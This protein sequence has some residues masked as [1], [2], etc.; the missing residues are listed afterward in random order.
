MPAA[1][2]KCSS[3]LAMEQF[4]LNENAARDLVTT[5]VEGYKQRFESFPSELFIH[6]R[7]PFADEEWE[8]FQSAV[9]PET[10]IVGVRIRDSAGLRLYTW[11]DNVALRGLALIMDDRH[12]VLQSSGWIPR[13]Q[14]YPGRE[15]P[16]PLS[17]DILRG[18]ADIRTVLGDVLALTKLNYNACLYSDG[19]PVTLKFADSIG[20]ILTA[21]PNTPPPPLPFKFYI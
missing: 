1:R 2:L 9:P 6:G 18:D 21:G 19:R 10:R 3:I 8:G 12:A 7:A 4:H 13:L 5:A 15:I 16:I 20:T 14:T 11:T 17:V